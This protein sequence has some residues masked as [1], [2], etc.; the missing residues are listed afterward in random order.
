M[1]K[2]Q[3]IIAGLYQENCYLIYDDNSLLVIDPG[4]KSKKLIE[5]IDLL[6]REVKAIL[7]THGHYDHTGACDDLK[8]K[9]HCPIYASKDDEPL[10]RNRI[11]GS[12]VT[13]EINWL[14]G[15]SLIF[16]DINVE[17]FYTPGHSEGSV[18]YKIEDKLFSGDTLFR[19]SVGRTDL[20]GGSNHKLIQSLRLIETF[21]ENVMVYPG[22]DE[23]T[24]IGFELD[25]NPYL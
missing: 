16:G 23:T 20:Y 25:N 12:I 24:T 10:L 7:L 14:T 22:H 9:Y 4:G 17:I 18:M 11:N 3:T 1:V 6:Q 15:N 13:S 2:V 19:L 5:I 8:N 21:D